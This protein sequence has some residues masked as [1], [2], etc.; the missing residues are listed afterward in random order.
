ML[1]H[2]QPDWLSL[3][4][5]CNHG[6]LSGTYEEPAPAAPNA[7]F[8]GNP[9]ASPDRLDASAVIHP[10]VHRIYIR[11]GEK[12]DGTWRDDE[13]Q[14]L[15]ATSNCHAKIPPP[16]AESAWQTSHGPTSVLRGWCA[17]RHTA[18]ATRR[19]RVTA[20]T[21]A[22]TNAATDLAA[23]LFFSPNLIGTSMNPILATLHAIEQRAER[24]IDRELQTMMQDILALRTSLVL[25]E[26]TEADSLLIKLDRL[27]SGHDTRA[28]GA[29]AQQPSAISENKLRAMECLQSPDIVYQASFFDPQ[30]GSLE[31][32]IPASSFA[33]AVQTAFN[34][35]HQ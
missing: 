25:G 34:R 32:V 7:N 4:S 35:L 6:G 23:Y 9:G 8:P 31:D 14:R 21:S 28:A 20:A 29:G 5:R 19:H 3:Q 16:N 17:M 27:L 10:L 15:Q 30:Y 11:F 13:I 12:L 2:D 18:T 1:F 22:A 26:R 33:C 24:A